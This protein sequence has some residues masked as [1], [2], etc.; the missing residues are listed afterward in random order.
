MGRKAKLVSRS[1]FSVKEV[2]LL[3]SCQGKWRYNLRGEHIRISNRAQEKALRDGKVMLK[4][5]KDFGAPSAIGCH[6][7]LAVPCSFSGQ[8]EAITNSFPAAA[9]TSR[10]TPASQELFKSISFPWA[11]TLSEACQLPEEG[12]WT[13]QYI[14]CPFVC[15]IFLVVRHLVFDSP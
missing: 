4:L 14:T 10:P 5:L 3:K 8:E 9:V 12:E 6:C 1:E 15:V 13:E 11:S 7:H 2:D